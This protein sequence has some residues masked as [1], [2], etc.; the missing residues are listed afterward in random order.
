MEKKIT[1]ALAGNPN[2]GKTSLFNRLTGARAHVGN[3]PGVT[4]EKK[5]GRVNHGGVEIE[6]VDLPG[7]Y[8]LTAYSLEELAARR[9]ILEERPD[10]VVDVVDAANLER[11]LYLAVQFMEIGVPVVI[12]L[13]MMD[14]AEQRGLRIDVEKLSGL[15]GVEV[16]PTVARG[17]KGMDRLLDAV[18]RT[19][20]KGPAWEPKRLRYGRDLDLR[21]SEICRV[22]EENSFDPGLISPR[23]LAVKA[24]EGDSEVMTVLGTNPRVATKVRE[25][26]LEVARHLRSTVDDEPEGVIADHRYGFITSVTKQTVAAV[27][28][29]RFTLSD[30]IDLVVLNR[31]LGPL[32]LLFV[33]YGVY[34]FTFWVSELPVACLEAFFSWLSGLVR[35]SLPEGPVRSLLASGIIDGVGGVVGFVPLIAFM[36]FAIAVLEDSGYMARIAFILD[37]VLRTF[38]LHGNSVLALMVGG[39]IS[40]GCAVPGVMAARTLRDPQE[41]LATI[42]VTP[43]MNCGA[44]LPVF[45]IF[46]AAFFPRH[47]ARMLFILTLVAWVMALLAARI[48]RWTILRGDH[49]PF[50]MELPPYR[51]PTLRGLFIHSWERVWD[52]L[53]KAGTV[54]LGVSIVIWAMMTYPGLPDDLTGVFEHQRQAIEAGFLGGPAGPY[55]ADGDNLKKADELFRA[56]EGAGGIPGSQ[57]ALARLVGTARRLAAQKDVPAELREYLPVAEAYLERRKSLAVLAEAQGLAGLRYSAAGRLGIALEGVS[58]PLGFDWRANIALVGG[59]A[60]KE[61][62]VSTLGTAYSLG[63]GVDAAEESLSS[64]LAREPGWNPLTGLV[65]MLFVMMYSPC[66]V[67]LATIGREAGWRW[68]LFAMTYTTVS[69]YLVCLAVATIGRVLGL[70][71]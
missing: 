21:I 33:L 4:V 24:L 60:A 12:A 9:F 38:G 17:G 40:G 44:K 31:L 69:A 67:T 8:S 47:Q 46:I 66:S 58:R 48:L 2:A 39:G 65:M 32:V 25:I 10:L 27:R 49:T 29:I 61:V 11:N 51:L 13:N 64:R 20:E 43:L 3:Y 62:V 5:T 19:A 14:M 53:K 34:Q 42:L 63:G 18:V 28:D 54:I 68:A 55:L 35:A 45:L 26:V 71:V 37:R 70:G 50:V 59:F 6:V 56:G 36:F 41:R 52:Y 30:R 7:T 16:V 57:D 22:F 15:L 1:I 23:W